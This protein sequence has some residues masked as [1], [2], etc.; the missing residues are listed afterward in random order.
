MTLRRSLVAVVV[1]AALVGLLATG[2]EPTA[3]DAATFTRLGRPTM[4]FVPNG[5]F[6]TASWFCPGVPGAGAPDAADGATGGTVAVVNPGDE[7]MTGTVTAFSSSPEAGPSRWE[8][9]V[10]PRSRTTVELVELQPT[11]AYVSALVEIEGGGGF[12]E[13]VAR[14]P[15]GAVVAPCANA[16]S[17]TWYFAD[18][19]TVGGSSEQLVLTNPYPREAVVAIGFVTADGVRR[20]SRLQNLVVPGRSVQVVELGARDEPLV[21]A[22]VVASRG[23]VIAG[24]AQRYEGGGRSG[25]SMTLGAP[26]LSTQYWFADG[27]RAEGVTEQYSIFNPTDEQVS[28]SVVFLGAPISDDFANDTEIVVPAGRA[29]SFDTADVAGLPQGRHGAVFSTFSA[30]SIVVE[31]AITRPAGDGRTTSV[32]MGAPPELAARR[33]SAA[34]S[35]ELALD[36]VIVVLNADN[37]DTTVTVRSLGPGGLAPVPGLESVPLP[38]GGLITLPVADPTALGAPFVVES[39]QSTFVQRLLPRG[40]DLR[41]RSAS[42]ALA[43]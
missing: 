42:F 13:Q 23:R 10:P 36:D 16:A 30:A 33:W 26:S 20:P 7:A 14:H 12:V 11:G 5:A 8:I 37:I 32:V 43:G 39:G 15:D 28:V 35:S 41:G 27:E 9:T 19:F 3:A 22:Q 4:P 38:A 40:A 25:F 18:G 1:L 21:A 2:R 34:V 17:S 31:Q 24:R 6:I 29:V